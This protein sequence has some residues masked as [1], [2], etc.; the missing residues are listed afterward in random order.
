MD[1]SKQEVI[2]SRTQYKVLKTI[3]IRGGD[4]SNNCNTSD[5]SKS[6]PAQISCWI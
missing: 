6:I 1:Q 2:A 3:E 5:S 4:F